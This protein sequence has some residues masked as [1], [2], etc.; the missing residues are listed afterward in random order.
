MS[1]AIHRLSN[2]ER[3][4]ALARIRSI[5]TRRPSAS[6]AAAAMVLGTAR[7]F[8]Q[9]EECATESF[10]SASRLYEDC[11]WEFAFE[12][13]AL[14][15]DQGNAPAAKLALL[16][17]RYGSA[18]YGTGFNAKPEQVAR[19]AQRVLRATSRA[20]ASPSSITASA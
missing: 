15:A 5:S 19:W 6:L 20:T 9:T 16:M 8:G 12:R 1:N 4:R 11:H 18:I 14:L 13:L 2:P 7:A 10:I 17:L 3:Q